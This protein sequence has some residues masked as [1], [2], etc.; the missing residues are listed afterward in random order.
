MS[1]TLDATNLTKAVEAIRPW[2]WRLVIWVITVSFLIASLVSTAI[3]YMIMRQANTG[4]SNQTQSEAHNFSFSFNPTLSKLQ[5]DRV[6]ERN[7]FNSEG[8]IGDVDPNSAGKD[9][10]NQPQ[11]TS[12]PVKIVGLIYGGNPLHG[13]AM[14]ENTEKRS[15]NSFLVG[16]PLTADATA[17]IKEIHQDRVLIDNQG[18]IEF[19]MLEETEIRRS[20]RKGKKTSPARQEGQSSLAGSGFATDPPP[21]NFKEEG[22]E[23]KGHAIEMTQEY[24]NRLLTADFASV[25]QDAKASPNVVDGVLRGWKMDRIRKG[26]IYEKAGVQN[27]D[28]VEEINGVMLSDAAQA[29]KTLQSLKNED[30]IELRVVREGKAIN[31]TFKVR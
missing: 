23:R 6:I 7:I 27:N 25:L 13:L 4:P 17:T 14:I 8:Q 31:I 24:K 28:I 12:L 9:N 3:G 19:A 16:D 1:F 10:P 22:F 21:E 26:S 11:K 30:V 15:V 2:P 29:V 5:V 18:R 20:S